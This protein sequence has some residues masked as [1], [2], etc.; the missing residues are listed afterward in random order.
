MS[1]KKKRP[2]DEHEAPRLAVVIVHD[3]A[4]RVELGDMARR[5]DRVSQREGWEVGII[6]PIP[7]PPLQDMS[8]FLLDP[9]M[10]HEAP[11]AAG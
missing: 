11:N 5:L 10:P 8:I 4:G 7:H 1:P 9:S 6:L 3:L 2:A